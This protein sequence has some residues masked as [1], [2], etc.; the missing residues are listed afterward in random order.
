MTE[1]WPNAE[2][3][4]KAVDLADELATMPRL[5]VASMLRCLVTGDHRTL[6]ESLRDERAAFHATLGSA[7]QI[8]GLTAFMQKRPPVFNRD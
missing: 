5:A 6:Q 3:K 1:V 7:D 8:E 4:Q 2:L